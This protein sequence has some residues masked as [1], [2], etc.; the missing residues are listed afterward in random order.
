MPQPTPSSEPVSLLVVDVDGVWLWTDEDRRLVIDGAVGSAVPDRVGG[1]VYQNVET[2][3]W[4][5]DESGTPTNSA[6]WKWVGADSAQPIRRVLRPG[7][8]SE[9]VVEPPSD[10]MIRIVDTAI[11]DGQPALAYLRTRHFTITTVDENPW[12]DSRTA[13][14]VVRDLTTGLERVVRIQSIGWEYDGRAPSL[15]ELAVAEAVRGYGDGGSWIELLGFD[16]RSIDRSADCDY[17]CDLVA[18]LGPTGSQLVYVQRRRLLSERIDRQFVMTVVDHR[19]SAE[20]MRTEFSLPDGTSLVSL[21]TLDGRTVAV[22]AS[23]MSQDAATLPVLRR[24]DRGPWVVVLQQVMSQLRTPGLDDTYLTA[25]G[26]FGAGTEAA[27]RA[28]QTSAGLDAD[29]I[30]GSATWSQLIVSLG[31]IDQLHDPVLIE[32]D[33]STR[34]PSVVMSDVMSARH[35][36]PVITLWGEL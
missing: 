26:V 32:A 11:V 28:L 9:I 15:G 13:E 5:A 4:R 24:G 27:V 25:D 30:V 36:G 18:D 7:G 33:G 19:T 20:Q 17:S 14:L 23:E 22:T 29:G 1:I 12:P 10:G 16:G 21:D 31:S 6:Q 3:A 2:G 34:R 8:T 35:A